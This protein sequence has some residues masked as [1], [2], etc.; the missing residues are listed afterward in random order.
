MSTS[1]SPAR[2]ST[3]R[4]A[5]HCPRPKR[6]RTRWAQRASATTT[7]WSP[8]TTPVDPS[9]PGCGGCCTSP[10]IALRCSTCPSL[11]TW[12]AIGG[13]LATGAGS[14]SPEPAT[15][16]ARALARERIADADDVRASLTGAT[17]VVVDARAGERYRGEVEPI[18]PVAGHIPGAVSAA[19]VGQPRSTDRTAPDAR[20]APVAVRR[21]R[22]ARRC[23]HDRLVRVGRHGVSGRVGDGASRPPRRPVVR[24]VLVGLDATIR[25]DRSR[26]APNPERC[27]PC[28]D[29]RR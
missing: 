12:T 25:R 27:R 21:T 5:I 16:T 26:P 10:A 28:G 17:G 3:V 8:T 22:G 19:W 18:D 1:T 11:E 29:L 14:P 15:F 4:A 20:G 23:E 24:G 13:A 6:S 2:R 7:S 9:R